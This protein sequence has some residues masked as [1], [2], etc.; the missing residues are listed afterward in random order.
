MRDKAEWN[1]GGGKDKYLDVVLSCLLHRLLGLGTLRPLEVSY[2]MCFETAFPGNTKQDSFIHWIPLTVDQDGPTG[3]INF[4][5]TSGL[6]MCDSWE[7]PQGCS[8]QQ[9]QRGRWEVQG[10]ARCTY[11]M[12]VEVSKEPVPACGSWGWEDSERHTR[13]DLHTSLW[14][15]KEEW[16][17]RKAGLEL[18]LRVPITRGSNSTK[19]FSISNFCF[20]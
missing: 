1:R 15:L 11:T 4:P 10:A 19:I 8:T 20:S 14:W 9:R 13:H 16:R 12:R 3:I 2:K 7:G 5:C 18:S 17:P 6:Y